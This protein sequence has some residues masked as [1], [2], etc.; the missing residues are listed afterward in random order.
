MTNKTVIFEN[1]EVGEIGTFSVGDAPNSCYNKKVEICVARDG[2]EMI[3]SFFFRKNLNP[4]ICEALS[5][6]AKAMLEEGG[7]EADIII[8]D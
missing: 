7:E 5:D 4:K 8:T 3:A 6:L 1:K 2:I